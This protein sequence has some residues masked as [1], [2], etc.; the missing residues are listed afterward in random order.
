MTKQKLQ[1][2]LRG[3]LQTLNFTKFGDKYN[4]STSVCSRNYNNI[5]S[6]IKTREFPINRRSG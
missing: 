6:S 3:H 5:H 4:R 2:Q 1:S